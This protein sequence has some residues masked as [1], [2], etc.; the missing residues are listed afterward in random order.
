MFSRSHCRSVMYI[1]NRNLLNMNDA[2]IQNR[3]S[4]MINQEIPESVPLTLEKRSVA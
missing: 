4:D 3:I 2:L 1:L